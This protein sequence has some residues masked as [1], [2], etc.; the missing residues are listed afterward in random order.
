[1][2][3]IC[4]ECKL[5]ISDKALMCPHCGFPLQPD[6]ISYRK[7]RSNKRK[8][9]PNGF[10]QIS[11]IKGK[12]LRKPFRA[13]VTVGKTPEGR[14]I[15]KPLKPESYFHTYN[16]A[17]A[18]LVE[19]NKDP[20]SLD[21]S[22]TVKELYEKWMAVYSKKTSNKSTICRMNNAWDHCVS[23]YNIQVTDLR[24]RHIKYCMYEGLRE[25]PDGTTKTPDPSM[26][27]KIKSMF[28]LMLDYAME[29]ELVDKNV[30]RAFN[31]PKEVSKEIKT[32]NGHI[33]YSDEEM[34]VL[35]GNKGSLI[36]DLILI[37]CYSGWRP[38]EL[39][40]LKIDD[41]DFDRGS[42][43]GGMKTEA[44]TDREVPIHPKILPL[45]KSY[46]NKA[47]EIDSEYIFNNK[48][49]ERWTRF[50]PERYRYQLGKI[51]NM[52]NLNEGHR[53]H[54][55]RVFFVTNAKKYGVDEYAI[56]YIVGHAIY[57]ITE[58]VYTKRDFNWLTSEMK[59]II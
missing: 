6:K 8:R 24:T 10:G 23:V 18:A 41:I 27:C 52:Y 30:S 47:K 28:N 51:K 9:L 25:F 20:Y 12:N 56:K 21:S 54:D 53:P 31:I 5:Q 37:Q 17:Y 29:Y 55:G 16:D 48:V 34:E 1:M 35:W 2:L 36:V 50:T 26:Q 45:I 39:C 3:I 4:S 32:K 38:Q 14:P 59:K 19:Y 46:Y 58:A 22:I 33:S 49:G 43:T 44:G 40:G 15:C 11:E 7:P 57:D 13:M 42:M